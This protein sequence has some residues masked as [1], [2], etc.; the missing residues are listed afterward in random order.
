VP[1]TELE[2]LRE[3]RDLWA[4]EINRRVDVENYLINAYVG[5]HPPPDREKCFELA[6]K[7]G[8]ALNSIRGAEPSILEAKTPT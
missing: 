5:K 6:K 4:K 2:T 8:C 3:L 1:Y 7:L